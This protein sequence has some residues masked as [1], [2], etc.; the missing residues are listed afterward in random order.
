MRRGCLLW[1]VLGVRVAMGVLGVLAVLVVMVLSG[2]GRLWW[3][4]VLVGMRV[5][6]RWWRGWRRWCGWCWG[7]GCWL[8]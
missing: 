6:G 1:V 7:W 2:M 4:R 3:V 8:G 5:W